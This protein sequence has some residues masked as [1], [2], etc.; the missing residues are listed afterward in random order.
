MAVTSNMTLF[1]VLL[2]AALLLY[3]ATRSPL[4]VE[5]S[6]GAIPAIPSKIPLIGHILGIMRHKNQYYVKL[7]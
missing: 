3:F 7:R 1:L 6:P 2:L 5:N 4:I